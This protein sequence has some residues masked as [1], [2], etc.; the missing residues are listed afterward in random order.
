M[1]PMKKYF[2]LFLL[3]L[4]FSIQARPGLLDSLGLGSEYDTPPDVDEVFIFSAQVQDPQTLSARW[5]IAEGNYL[6]R[7]KIQ[8]E[9]IGNDN[10]RI[11]IACR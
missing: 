10:V 4:S 11:F 8:F 1:L 3:V 9:L 2:F 7:D 6:Y 5:Q